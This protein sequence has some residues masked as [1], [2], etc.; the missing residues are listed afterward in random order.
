MAGIIVGIVAAVT[1]LGIAIL[2]YRKK[3]RAAKEQQE[4]LDVDWDQIEHQFH[5][6]SPTKRESVVSPTSTLV[7]TAT[8]V[9]NAVQS[10]DTNHKNIMSAFHERPISRTSIVKP[11]GGKDDKSQLP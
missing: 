4:A 8:Q 7:A 10:Q 11:D 3:K 2:L 6:I 1:V 5:E 9:P